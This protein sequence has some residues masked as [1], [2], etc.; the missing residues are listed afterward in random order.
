[1]HIATIGLDIA[2]H[3]FQ[4]HAVD[5]DGA[6]VIRKRYSRAQLVQLFE[7]IPPCLVGI[8]AC[9]TAH[10]W[11]RK[12][13][14]LGHDVRLMPAHYVKPYVKRGKNDA[15]DAEG[16]CEAVTRPTMRFV[17][18]KAPDTQALALMHRLRTQ[19]VAQRTAMLNALRA[20]MAEFGIVTNQGLGGATEILRIACAGDE[21][22]PAM[23]RDAYRLLADAIRAVE[24][25]LVTLDH[26]IAAST[27][28]DD[29]CKRLSTIPGVG[30]VTSTTII[31]LAGDV[32][33]FSSGRDFAAWL[34]LTPRQNSTGGKARLG[35]ITKAGDQT[36]RTLLVL[37]AF[38]V[39]KRARVAPEKASPWLMALM[40]RRPPLVAA[41]A[42]AN[43]MARII[44]AILT[45]GGTFR[46]PAR[47]A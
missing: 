21:R 27:Q 35:R 43:K 46:A 26:Q 7:E 20:G 28:F 45:R 31:A 15:A 19:F 16:I 32:S 12:L 29:T 30:P 11:G 39:I 4:V 23:I 5:T 3:V 14:A 33:R 13:Q 41:V 2:K 24:A 18:I 38:S 37:G 44:W 47:A 17:P 42:L 22:L 9:G 25:R 40:E 34:G 36:L 8:E 1:M 6:V 10:Y